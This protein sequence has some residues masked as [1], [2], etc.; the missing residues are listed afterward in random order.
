MSLDH[1]I[2]NVPLSKRGD[3]DKQI[4]AYKRDQAVQERQARRKRAAQ[5]AELRPQA[6]AAVEVLSADAIARIAARAR[7][8]PA[9]VKKRLLSDAHWRPE[10]VLR[11]FPTQES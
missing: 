9:R 10:Q 11:A 7:L 6:K 4:D 2:L 1:G 3:I 8:T 5:L